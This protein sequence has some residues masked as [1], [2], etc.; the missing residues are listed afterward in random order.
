MGA[1]SLDFGGPLTSE[2][3]EAITTFLR[4]WEEGAPDVENWRDPLGLLSGG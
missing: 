2:Q 1:Y 3:I 4:A